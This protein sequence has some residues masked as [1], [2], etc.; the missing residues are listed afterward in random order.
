MKIT[1]KGTQRQNVLAEQNLIVE[2]RKI[3]GTSIEC[4]FEDKSVGLYG[5]W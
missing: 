1:I 3:K 5:R 4:I 2:E